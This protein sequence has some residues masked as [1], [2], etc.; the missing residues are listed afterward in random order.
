MRLL[1]FFIPTIIYPYFS[2]DCSELRKSAKFHE[3]LKQNTENLVLHL[4]S[5]HKEISILRTNVDKGVKEEVFIPYYSCKL[6]VCNFFR[7]SLD[8]LLLFLDH[9]YPF[10]K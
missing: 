4:T 3:N 5:I 7:E 8:V 6:R 9:F 1:R 10:D 2:I